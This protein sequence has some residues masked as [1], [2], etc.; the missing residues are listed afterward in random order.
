MIF[1]FDFFDF[2]IFL[3]FF[4]FFKFFF[5]FSLRDYIHIVLFI[6]LLSKSKVCN[7]N[8]SFKVKAYENKV[9]PDTEH[10]FDDDFYESLD[11]VFS[12][13]L[14]LFLVS[15]FLSFFLSF[16][17]FPNKKFKTLIYY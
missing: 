11:F 3:D 16:F 17:F 15:F 1:F 14:L 4:D 7:M 6:Y 2:L 13:S 5:Q 10:L 12:F 8:P 9:A